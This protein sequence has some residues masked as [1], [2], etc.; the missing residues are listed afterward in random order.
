MFRHTNVSE[1]RE[2]GISLEE[3][4]KYEGHSS[5]EITEKVYLHETEER[6]KRTQSILEDIAKSI[7]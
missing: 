1:L 5:I 7:I 4:Q 6:K 3:I 2:K